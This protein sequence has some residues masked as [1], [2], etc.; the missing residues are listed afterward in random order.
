MRDTPGSAGRRR[1]LQG[2][3]G[4]PLLAGLWPA[5][6]RAHPALAIPERAAQ[7]LDVFQLKAVAQAKLAPPAWHFIAAH[8]DDGKTVAANRSVMDD[9]LIRVRR[10]VDVSHIDTS[11]ELLGERLATPICI[12]PVGNQLL[13]HPEAE[14]A[15]ARAA[16]RRRN[17][18]IVSTVSSMPVE[19]IAAAA[20]GPL[21]F[22]LYASRDTA[23]MRFLLQRAER[24]GCRTVVLTVDSPTRGNREAERWFAPQIDRSRLRLG[25]FEG[26]P[27]GPRIGDPALDWGI[28]AWLRDN[29]RMQLVL[30]GIVTG[31]DAERCVR[32]GV[33]GLIVS[34]HGGRQEESG[35]GT[36]ACLPEVVAAAGGLPVL[37][38]GGFRR[39]TD[40]FKALALGARAVCLG[41]P[42]L[43]GLGAFGQ[44]G[45]AR[46]LSLLQAELERIM[47][48]AGT[49]RLDEISPASL[50][51]A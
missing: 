22:Q 26:Y 27:G 44:P 14:L 20:K 41:R 34:N 17:L 48:F 47:R 33:D 50:E 8:A 45:V 46:V 43:W 30:K 6:G 21:W 40:V 42:C 19:E 11:L 1:L 24:A 29:T 32:H 4:T 38:D 28:V 51:R 39:G 15:S 18:M 13:I 16:S 3:L 25:N 37:I 7:A 9:W 5:A 49:R 10:L 2:L 12:A 31:E 35:R 36:L 23:L